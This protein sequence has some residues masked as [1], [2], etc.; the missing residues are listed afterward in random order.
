MP[1]EHEIIRF[2][3]NIPGEEAFF[4]ICRRLERGET[5]HLVSYPIAAPRGST[6]VQSRNVAL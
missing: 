1:L 5:I 6:A 3:V 4:L 2:H